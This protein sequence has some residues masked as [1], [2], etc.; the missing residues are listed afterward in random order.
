[1]KLPVYLQQKWRQ[2][3]L[4]KKNHPKPESLQAIESKNQSTSDL[5]QSAI[6]IYE[7]FWKC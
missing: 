3:R 2:L 5:S 1:M 6:N 7:I 4:K